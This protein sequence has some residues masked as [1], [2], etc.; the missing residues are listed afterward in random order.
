MPDLPSVPNF[1]SMTTEAQ[2]PTP[3]LMA[4]AQVRLRSKSGEAVLCRAPRNWGKGSAG[5]SHLHSEQFRSPH[6]TRLPPCGRLSV[7]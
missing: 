2:C 6:K 4:A 7:R 5:N 1:A 3:V